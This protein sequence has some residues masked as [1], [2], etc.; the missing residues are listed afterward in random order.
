MVELSDHQLEI[1][2]IMCNMIEEDFWSEFQHRCEE[3]N[4]DPSEVDETFGELCQIVN[5]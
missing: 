5:A 2:V 3:Q 4:W 1:I